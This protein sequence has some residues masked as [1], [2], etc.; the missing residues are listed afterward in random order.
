MV[1]FVIVV[2]LS[3]VGWGEAREFNDPSFSS[4]WPLNTAAPYNINV[5]VCNSMFCCEFCVCEWAMCL[6]FVNV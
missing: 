5:Q 2:V 4:Q 1:L 3:V 6:L